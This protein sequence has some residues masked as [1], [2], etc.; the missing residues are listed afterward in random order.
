MSAFGVKAN[1]GIVRANDRLGATDE[2]RVSRRGG[3]QHG[4]A[5][6]NNPDFGELAWS[7]K[8]GNGNR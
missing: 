1:I 6:Q 4:C 8:Q 5:R 2:W 7:S 3:R